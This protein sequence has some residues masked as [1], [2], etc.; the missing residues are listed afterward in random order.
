[1]LEHITSV[2][3]LDVRVAGVAGGSLARVERR[4]RRWRVADVGPRSAH[5][6][7]LEY[8]CFATPAAARGGGAA[9]DRAAR[10]RP[11]EYAVLET[12]AG[13]QFALTPTCAANA[14][15]VVPA[16]SYSAG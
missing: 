7:G 13:A 16:G 15:G 9:A 1:M 3:S 5:I 2:R 12:P 11:A 8:A 14:L 6:A 10:G 4:G